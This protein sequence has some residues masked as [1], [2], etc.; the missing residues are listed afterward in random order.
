[1][2]NKQFWGT[3][4]TGKTTSESVQSW[5]DNQYDVTSD[6]QDEKISCFW[7]VFAIVDNETKHLGFHCAEFY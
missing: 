1:M 4:K 2:A 5:H 7:V 6:F 3:N